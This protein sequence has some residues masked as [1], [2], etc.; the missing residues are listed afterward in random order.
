MSESQVLR[1]NPWFATL[2]PAL[3]DAVLAAG[4]AQK[5]AAGEVL[6]RQGDAPG[7]WHA[8]CILAVLEPGNWFGE[9]SLLDAGPRVHDA[10]AVGAT[11]VFAVPAEAFAR[12]M[13]DP[14][15]ATALARL[16]A[17]RLRMLF[18]M[19]EDA[20]LR[21]TRARLARRLALLAR[22]DATLASEP[23][24]R[25]PVSQE[26]LAMMLG[27]TR[28]TLSKELGELARAGALKLGYRSI[29]IVDAGLLDRLGD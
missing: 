16:M 1:A 29:D 15:F 7:D 23:R 12:F 13:Q 27:L 10:T 14:V 21:P 22:G 18:G 20:T 4:R 6:F 24:Q 2:P 5:L 8:V 26:A 3:A 17:G 9:I 28:Q 19:L 25:L 11:A